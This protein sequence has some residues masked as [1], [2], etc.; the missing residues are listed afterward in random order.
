MSDENWDSDEK[1]TTDADDAKQVAIM[2]RR[3]IV[4]AAKVQIVVAQQGYAYNSQELDGKGRRKKIKQ[5]T[6][7]KKKK[8]YNRHTQTNKSNKR[9][10]L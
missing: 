9:I 3:L 2:I 4:F 6:K 5:R 10:P 8:N 7:P 1:H